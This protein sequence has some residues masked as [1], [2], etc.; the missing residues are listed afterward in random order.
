MENKDMHTYVHDILRVFYIYMQFLLT[1]YYITMNY[2]I[3]WK[4]K[5]KDRRK[6][7]LYSDQRRL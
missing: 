2:V 6:T 1:M 5:E 7:N 4:K 3:Y